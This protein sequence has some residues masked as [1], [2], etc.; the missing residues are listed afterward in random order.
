MIPAARIS[1]AVDILDEILGGRAAEAALTAWGR[2]H[3]FAGSGDRA[4]IRDHVYDAL[5]CRRSFAA[6][7]GAETG[8]GLMI[9]ALRAAGQDPAEIFTGKGHA[10]ARL[11]N[12]ESAAGRVPEGAEARDCPDWLWPVLTADLGADAAPVLEALRHRAPVFVRVNSARASRDDAAARLAAEGIATRPHAKVSTALE[13]VE[14]PRRITGSN[15]FRDGLIELQ[16]AHSQEV[17]NRLP[18]PVGARILD[19]CA[20]AGGKTLALAARTGGTVFA[21]D[22]DPRRMRD[23]PAR[24]ARAGATVTRVAAADLAGRFDLVLCDVPCSGSGSWRRDP[25]GKWALTPDR[26]AALTRTQDAIL[27]AAAPRVGPGGIL[28]YATCSVLTRENAARIDAFLRRMPG[29]REESRAVLRP[30]PDGDGFA[31]FVL[32]R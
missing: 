29:W 4:A 9:G 1:A 32:R 12:A 15:A 6:L 5:R 27:D 16:D 22:A 7:G 19:Y 17:V 11:T 28:A 23:L 20:G 31:L 8:R 25:Q 14:N 24:A 10:P 3:R 26:L 30:G 21:H 2:G 13:V 18:I